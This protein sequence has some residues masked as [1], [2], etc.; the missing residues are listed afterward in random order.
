VIKTE[1]RQTAA[2][3][4]AENKK[5]FS[6]QSKQAKASFYPK[7]I[8]TEDLIILRAIV[9]FLGEKSQCGWWDTDFLS[10]TGLEFLAINFPRSAFSAGCNSVTEAAKRLHDE[11]IG[12]GGVYHL[13][14]LPSYPEEA[15]HRN[16]LSS[17]YISIIS[18]LSTRD[19]ALDKL[20]SF[21]TDKRETPEGPV[22]IGTLEDTFGGLAVSKLSMNYYNA[23]ISGKMCF[24]YFAEK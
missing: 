8:P 18:C 2:T 24:P 7:L 21:F 16:L 13:F 15:I 20:K 14:R 5:D 10:P 19:A 23:F 6:E 9:G 4:S 22:Q 1:S 12:K 11:R 17:E 3:P